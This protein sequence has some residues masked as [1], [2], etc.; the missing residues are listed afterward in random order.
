MAYTPSL[1]FSFVGASGYVPSG[2]FEFQADAVVVSA[3]LS[4]T[5]ADAGA[6]LVGAVAPRGHLAVTLA[7]AS[8]QFGGLVVSNAARMHAALTGAGGA[9]AAKYSAN[10]MR[11]TVGLAAANQQ[12]GTWAVRD[13]CMPL[14]AT[15]MSSQPCHAI[16]APA[17]ARSSRVRV[18]HDQAWLVRAETGMPVVP[19]T[20]LHGVVCSLQQLLD[21]AVRH[22]TMDVD[23]AAP[24]HAGTAAVMQQMTKVR[25]P[26]WCGPVQDSSATRR[27]FIKTIA[28]EPEAP[29]R[30]TP[31]SAYGF[32]SEQGY[33]SSWVFNFPAVPR[34]DLAIR[35]IIG[36]DGVTFCADRQQAAPNSAQ[37][38]IPV[39][40]ARRPPPGK[41]LLPE[42][43]RPPYEPPPGHVTVTIQ[44]QQVYIMQHVI[45]VKTVPGNID[46][47][48]GNVSLSY[49][50]DSFAWQFSGTLL[51]AAALSLVAAAG[52]N[53]VML[54]V[55]IDGLVW[56]VLVEGIEHSIRFAQRSISLSGRSL[57]AL[58]GAPYVLPASATQGSDMTVQQL[59]DSLMP[60]GWTINWNAPT[61]IVPAGAWSYTNQTP[62]QALVGLVADIGCVA[63]PHNSLQ[64]ITVQPRYPVYPWYFSVAAADLAIPEAAL[65]Q[66]S[67]RPAIATQANGVYVHGGDIGGVLGWCRLAGSAG[68]RLAPTVSNALMTDVIGCRLLGERILSGQQPAPVI[69]SAT[70]PLDND[71][72]PLARVGQLVA[73]TLGGEIVKGVINSVAIEAGLDSVNQTIQIGEETANVWT[74]FTSLLPRDPLLVGTVASSAN[75]VSVVTLLD[76]GVV[77]VRGTG[78]VGGRVYIRAGRI[79][80]PAPAMG[81][82]EIVV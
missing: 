64:Q 12:N 54:A 21:W 55:T 79:E 7:G 76:G 1:V 43:E 32:Q 28:S 42:P 53:P 70:L 45:S 35:Q 63:V 27:N 2:Q 16:L 10:V 66:V 77:S 41:S 69:K 38:C 6:A 17:A 22:W 25:P 65:K 52:G 11:Y 74:A 8:G 24:I 73:I 71:V 44:T 40:Q 56:H 30:Y 4:V 57:T 37:L 14:V 39:E 49:D 80:G 46:I 62:I 5:L 82:N 19:A 26:D 59:A 3:A 81:V 72:F 60:L 58:L 50:A 33:T 48:M 29:W 78:T 47:P 31:G 67:L 68:D 51:D 75:D 13:V 61:W 9:L 20:S 34:I 23:V 36:L 15:L 18:A